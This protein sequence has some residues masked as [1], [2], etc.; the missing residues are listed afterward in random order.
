MP[1]LH[2]YSSRPELRHLDLNIARFVVS[3]AC[4]LTVDGKH[5][6]MGEELPR[7]SLTPYALACQYERPLR[8]IEEVTYAFTVEGLREACEAHGVAPAP[9]A[10]PATEIVTPDLNALDR[11]G[12]IGLCEL[13]GLPASGTMRQ[14]RQRLEDFLGK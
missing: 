10:V 4:G 6:E 8:R 14:M 9:P 5:L 3:M 13:Y 12:M 2:L 7:G 11:D 1:A